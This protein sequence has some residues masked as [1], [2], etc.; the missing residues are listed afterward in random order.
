MLLGWGVG[1]A[2]AAHVAG[3]ERLAGLVCLGFPVSTLAGPRGQAGD[4]L[5]ELKTP[6][7]FVVGERSSQVLLYILFI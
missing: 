2:I 1:A 6:V 3:I 4:P 5:L 7:L